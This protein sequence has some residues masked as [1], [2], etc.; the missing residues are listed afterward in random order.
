MGEV[1]KQSEEETRRVERQIIGEEYDK[2]LEKMETHPDQ[3][4]ELRQ[5][6]EAVAIRKFELQTD[7][8]RLEALTDELAANQEM[9]EMLGNEYP[10]TMETIIEN[11]WLH[12]P[13]VDSLSPQMQGELKRIKAENPWITEFEEE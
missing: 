2:I 7:Q 4:W 11:A 3:K 9:A 5:E 6:L 10:V 13:N 1:G 8:E 12:V